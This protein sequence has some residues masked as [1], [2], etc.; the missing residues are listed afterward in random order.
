M[1]FFRSQN[2]SSSRRC[3]SNRCLI[4]SRLS[5]NFLKFSSESA[6]T[7]CSIP[8][9]SS[10]LSVFYDQLHGSGTNLLQGQGLSLLVLVVLKKP[11]SIRADQLLVLQF[12]AK[13]LDLAVLRGPE[14]LF[15]PLVLFV[16][17]LSP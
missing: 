9:L 13:G 1:P 3:S 10:S 8:R 5:L 16:Q 15:L 7:R 11:V 2:S 14:F 12:L 17:F 4:V 6:A